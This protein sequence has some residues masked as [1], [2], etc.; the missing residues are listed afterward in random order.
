MTLIAEIPAPQ[1]KERYPFRVMDARTVARTAKVKV[2]TMNAWVQRGLI[3]G[4]TIGASGRRRNIDI[5]TAT[6]IIV[7]A[8]L[9][10]FGIPPEKASD[11]VASIGPNNEFLLV[12]YESLGEGP[13]VVTA[14]EVPPAFPPIPAILAGRN[15]RPELSLIVYVDGLRQEARNAQEQW[16]REQ[17]EV[18]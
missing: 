18:R 16:E 14:L 8:G 17:G 15:L 11:I 12:E 13:Y 3:P 9:I 5:D 4:M 1:K 2:G 7:F 10:K 6:R